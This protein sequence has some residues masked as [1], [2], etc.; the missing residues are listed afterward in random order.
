MCIGVAYHSQ[1]SLVLQ[2]FLPSVHK[3]GVPHLDEDPDDVGATIDTESDQSCSSADFEEETGAGD[4]DRSPSPSVD[5][6]A[7]HPKVP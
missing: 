3:P 5:S 6:G 2:T 7:S 1:R 4:E